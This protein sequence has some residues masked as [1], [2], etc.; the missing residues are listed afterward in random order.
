MPLHDFHD[1]WN[2]RTHFDDIYW[3]VFSPCQDILRS[4]LCKLLPPGRERF[5]DERNTAQLSP[6]K[7]GLP[8]SCRCVRRSLLFS[9]THSAPDMRPSIVYVT[10]AGCLLGKP[11]HVRC[12]R[13]EF[14]SGAGFQSLSSA[15]PSS[16]QR[17][18]K[19]MMN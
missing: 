19:C 4:F 8:I 10:A 11:F 15:T 18:T 5:R 16:M 1:K 7:P 2:T 13:T 3:Y 17:R 6:R 9:P 12:Y 14:F